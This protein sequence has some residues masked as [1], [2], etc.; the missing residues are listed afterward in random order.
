[1][2]NENLNIPILIDVED[3]KLSLELTS[4]IREYIFTH[5]LIEKYREGM[6]EKYKMEWVDSFFD[7]YCVYILKKLKRHFQMTGKRPQNSDLFRVNFFQYVEMHINIK[8]EREK[9][10]EEYEQ[11]KGMDYNYFKRNNEPGEDLSHFAMHIG[12]FPNKK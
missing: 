1:M 3:D 6:G 2:I 4:E 9:L 8:E 7:L 5:S 12:L 10:P 11:N